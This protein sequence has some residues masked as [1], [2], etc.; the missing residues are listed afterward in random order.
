MPLHYLDLSLIINFFCT[1]TTL[2]KDLMDPVI[3]TANKVKTQDT[4]ATYASEVYSREDIE[5]SG[6]LTIY[7]FFQQNTSAAIM[8]SYGNTFNQMIDIRGLDLR[9]ATKIS[10][11]LSMVVD[12]IILTR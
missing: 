8:P 1:S 4:K 9:M 2:A 5:K 3:V 12:L 10:Q 11:L 7:D 6:A